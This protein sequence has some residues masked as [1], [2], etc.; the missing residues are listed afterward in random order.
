MSAKWGKLGRPT[1][2]NDRVRNAILILKD[3]GDGV[4]ETCSQLKI[5][6]ASYYKVLKEQ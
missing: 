2:M 1:T 6:P 3:K 4:R 5:G